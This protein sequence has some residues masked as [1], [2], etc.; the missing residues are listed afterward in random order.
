[1]TEEQQPAVKIPAE[2]QF[3]WERVV[4][5]LVIVLTLSVAVMAADLF[6]YLPT[7]A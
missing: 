5:L 6:G 7:P 4:G 2:I 1:M 3:P